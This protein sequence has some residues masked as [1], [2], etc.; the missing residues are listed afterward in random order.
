MS[1]L[2]GTVIHIIQLIAVVLPMPFAIKGLI[3]LPK[4]ST[5]MCFN[6]Y[7]KK[8][9]PQVD[10]S[11]PWLVVGSALSGQ[12]ELPKPPTASNTELNKPRDQTDDVGVSEGKS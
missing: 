2:L 7:S 6:L 11:N 4:Y 5:F 1:F 3:I 9:F 12:T 10:P 8:T